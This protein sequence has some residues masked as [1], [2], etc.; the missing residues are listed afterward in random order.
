MTIDVACRP[1]PIRA[2]GREEWLLRVRPTGRVAVVQARG[3]PEI[4]VGADA[5]ASVVVEIVEARL[6][7]LKLTIVGHLAR[8][9]PKA[10]AS[11]SWVAMAKAAAFAHPD[12]QIP[13]LFVRSWLVSTRS[14]KGGWE[15]SRLGEGGVLAYDV[16]IQY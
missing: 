2:D 4:P 11:A 7:V 12:P 16:E 15:R 9:A 13:C 10:A 1:E 8:R 3:S 6:V 5:R 14:E